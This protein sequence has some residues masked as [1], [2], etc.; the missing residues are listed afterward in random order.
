LVA[1]LSVIALVAWPSGALYGWY[2][3]AIRFNLEVYA[4]DAR[5]NVEVARR[6][7]DYAVGSWHWYIALSLIGVAQ[8]WRKSP[9]STIGLLIVLLTT[10]VSAIVQ[11]KGFQYHM[12]PILPLFA[13]LMAPVVAGSIR[14]LIF[15]RPR[16]NLRFAAGALICCLVVTGLSKKMWRNFNLQI[17]WYFGTVSMA[18]MLEAYPAGDTVTVNVACQLAV[19]V[20]DTV[21]EGRTV[22]FWGRPALVNYLARRRSPTRFYVPMLMLWDSSSSVSELRN[23]WA[24]EF[25][26]MLQREP[27]ELI[28][29]DR[30]T[31]GLKSSDNGT[32]GN[33]SFAAILEQL[34]EKRYTLDRQIGIVDCYRLTQ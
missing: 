23:A 9:Q 25:A 24:D 26:Q 15:H 19:C 30:Q 27:P 21:P 10:F 8:Y 22:L 28:L 11:H 29:V 4:P 32:S 17:G 7:F 18:Q 20:Q 5:T 31:D 2:E 14:E 12:G 33:A 3:C 1:T 6:L 34:R 16:R 13:L